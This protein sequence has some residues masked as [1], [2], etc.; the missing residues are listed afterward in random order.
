[1]TL[2]SPG[3][4]EEFSFVSARDLEERSDGGWGS[5]S[6]DNWRDPRESD[7]ESEQQEDS[8]EVRRA[9]CVRTWRV[10]TG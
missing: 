1:M 3:L 2:L 6:P 7:S 10:G 4:P 8:M 9:G 5:P